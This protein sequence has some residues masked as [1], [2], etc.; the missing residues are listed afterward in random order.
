MEWPYAV[1]R[2]IELGNVEAV[3]VLRYGRTFEPDE[4]GG[5]QL[6]PTREAVL[7]PF[8]RL[9]SHPAVDFPD[10]VLAFARIWGPLELCERHLRPL[11]H[12]PACQVY[13]VGLDGPWW[14]EPLSAWK[15]YSRSLNA[16]LGLV[17]DLGRGLAVRDPDLWR[18]LSWGVAGESPGVAQRI[19]LEGALSPPKRFSPRAA[20]AARS[21]PPQ[22]PPE[23]VPQTTGDDNFLLRTPVNS[24]EAV[25]A[26]TCALT[27]WLISVPLRLQA[28]R[29]QSRHLARRSRNGSGRDASIRIS[30]WADHQRAL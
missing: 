18:E 29:D 27:A 19:A 1:P 4:A 17:A 9:A 23:Q 8:A 30:G 6:A 2:K 14:A 13:Q 25:L 28:Y 22:W 3:P 15:A 20:L 5:Y 11:G 16:A 12:S 10:A 21:Q 7:Q 26:L 24:D